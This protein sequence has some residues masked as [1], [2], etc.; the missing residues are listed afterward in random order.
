[1]GNIKP[2]ETEYNGYKF[3][4]RLEA[5]W[6]VFFDAL[7]IKYHY[8]PE[9]FNLDGIYYLPDF[10]LDEYQ[11]YVEIK[12]FDKS[13]VNYIGDFNEWEQKCSLFRKKTGKAI[14]ICYDEPFYYYPARF[15]GWKTTEGSAESCETDAWFI[16]I[17]SEIKIVINDPHPDHDVRITEDFEGSDLVVTCGEEIT[18]NFSKY[19]EDI[20]AKA[21]VK[22]FPVSDGIGMI[23]HAQI[24]SRHA[25]FEHGEKPCFNT[26]SEISEDDE[27]PFI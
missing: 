7:G 15:F 24:E 12:P 16:E 11:V 4:S 14:I 18:R 26:S 27:T 17:D 9:G 1:M 25:R 13:V 6:A 23:A 19:A 5:R 21:R 8:E 2:I 10:Y 3:R 22:A 20:I